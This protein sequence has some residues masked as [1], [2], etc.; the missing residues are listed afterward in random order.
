MKRQ[1]SIQS[2]FEIF[3]LPSGAAWISLTVRLNILVVGAA[4]ISQLISRLYSRGS[5]LHDGRAKEI[6]G[7]PLVP[8]VGLVEVLFEGC[9]PSTLPF[10]C[11]SPRPSPKPRASARMTKIITVLMKR[12]S[13][14][15]LLVVVPAGFSSSRTPPGCNVSSS[16]MAT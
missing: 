11:L 10:L 14:L 1:R 12:N 15:G 13:F 7:D 9:A 2:Q 3:N 8:F 16:M 6:S 4:L 5:R